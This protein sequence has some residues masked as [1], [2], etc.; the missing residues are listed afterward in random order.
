M[1][2]NGPRCWPGNPGKK[3]QQRT[4]P[5]SILSNY[6][7]NITLLDLEVDVAERPDVFGIAFGCPVVGLAD[8][9]IRILLAEDIGNPEAADVVG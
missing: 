2:P 9:E 8:L 7:H 3:F 5:R 1:R 4:L 6:P